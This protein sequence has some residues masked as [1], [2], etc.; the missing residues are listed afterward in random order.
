MTALQIIALVALPLVWLFLY[1]RGGGPTRSQLRGIRRRSRKAGIPEEVAVENWRARKRGKVSM[2]PANLSHGPP[3]EDAAGEKAEFER[4]ASD[5]EPLRISVRR[6][7]SGLYFLIDARRDLIR[8]PYR[9]HNPYSPSN[10]SNTDFTLEEVARYL[11][12][13]V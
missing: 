2:L 5:A 8:N 12:E 4:L 7:I 1:P 3:V 13:N 11:A 6:Q 9:I 10:A